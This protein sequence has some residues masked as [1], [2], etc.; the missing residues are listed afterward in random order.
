MAEKHRREEW[1]RIDEHG[2]LPIL[3]GVV[4]RDATL[5]RGGEKENG[6]HC[7]VARGKPRS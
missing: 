2:K 6:R 7:L 1:P 4:V 3:E 5:A